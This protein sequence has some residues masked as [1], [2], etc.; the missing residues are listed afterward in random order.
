MSDWPPTAPAS[1]GPSNAMPVNPTPKTSNYQLVKGDMLVR[2]DT[3]AGARTATLPSA[4]ASFANGKGDIIVVK[5]VTPDE[6]NLTATGLSGDLIDGAAS[7]TT[8]D[9][10]GFL[11]M[12]STG[13]GWDVISR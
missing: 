12:Q 8:T 13:T 9:P 7:V 2:F 6:N 10:Y 5:K 3:A 1:S 4:A 11:M